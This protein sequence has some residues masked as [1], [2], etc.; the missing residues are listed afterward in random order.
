MIVGTRLA[1]EPGR[2]KRAVP[3]RSAFVGAVV[4]VLGV[5]GCL[6]LG[7]GLRSTV[8]DPARAG[9]TWD[10][11]AGADGCRC[12]RTSST[13]SSPTTM[14]P[15]HSARSGY[16]R[17]RSTA[18]RSR[19]SG[20]PA[21]DGDI[22]FVVLDGRAPVAADEVAMAP[23]TMD[24]LGLRIGDEIGVGPG[25]VRPARVVGRVLLPAT[26]HTDYDQSAWMTI[27]RVGA[28]PAARARRRPGE[29]VRPA[30][31]EGGHRRRR[32]DERLTALGV[33]YVG[34]PEARSR[35][36]PRQHPHPAGRPGA[37]SSR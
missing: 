35:R 25:S 11:A 7:R 19:R 29:G 13:P 5:V 36:G 24:E 8:D 9:V 15:T 30:P 12:R 28:S 31:L 17:S 6:T 32:A 2:G 21:L 14:S 37:C 26:S 4:G 16:G 18:A 22:D 23:V 27:G 1:V 3:V 34:S 33:E 20:P 10:L